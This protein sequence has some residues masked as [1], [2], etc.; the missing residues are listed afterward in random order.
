MEAVKRLDHAD[1][2]TEHYRRELS[3]CHHHMGI[4]YIRQK[5]WDMASGC[6]KRAVEIGEKYMVSGEA[7]VFYSDMSLVLCR[8]G[9]LKGAN[10]FAEKAR[11]CFMQAGSLW[12][13]PRQICAAR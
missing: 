7:G 9:D 11:S 2:R 3:A 12:G 6:L 5:K 4:C 1:D 10:A 13:R 8:M